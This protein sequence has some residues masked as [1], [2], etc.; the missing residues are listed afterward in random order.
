MKMKVRRFAVT[1]ALVAAVAI[2]LGACQRGGYGNYGTKETLGTLG[3]AALGGFVGSQIGSGGGR[4]AATAAGVV[5]GGLLG[6]YVGRGLDEADRLE[7]ERTA[8]DALERQPD[9]YQ[10]TWQNPN[11]GNYGYTTPT[12]TYQTAGG[13][14]CRQYQT[15]VVIDGRAETATGTACRNDYTGEWEIVG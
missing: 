15:T 9:G 2:P 4:L 14:Y 3:G 12:S 11:S 5:L 8:F 10:S 7:A 13:R 6:N 1:A